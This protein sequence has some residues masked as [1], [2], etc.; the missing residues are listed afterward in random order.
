MREREREFSGDRGLSVRV[1][2][3]LSLTSYPSWGS[4]PPKRERD[5]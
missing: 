2:Q 3:A 5:S 1:D 4:V